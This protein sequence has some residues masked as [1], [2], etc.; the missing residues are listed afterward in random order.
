MRDFFFN[1]LAEEEWREEAEHVRGVRRRVFIENINDNK[2]TLFAIFFMKVMNFLIRKLFCMF[3]MLSHWS[4]NRLWVNDWRT[5]VC[6]EDFIVLG[7]RSTSIVTDDLLSVFKLL[8]RTF[9]YFV[10]FKKTL[11]FLLFSHQL[12]LCPSCRPVIQRVSPRPV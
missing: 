10:C 3:G 12:R 1:Y 11:S 6:T 5:S 2:H 8:W 4:W 9:L 7:R